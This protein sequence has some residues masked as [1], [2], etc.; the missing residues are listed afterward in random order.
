MGLAG[1]RRSASSC[2]GHP[3]QPSPEYQLVEN[4]AENTAGLL[5]LLTATP[6]QLGKESH[7]AR[8]R[9]LDPDRFSDLNRFLLEEQGYQQLAEQA[10]A[11]LEDPDRIPELDDLLDQHG[12]GRVLFRNTRHV[13]KGFPEREVHPV[14]LTADGDG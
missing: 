7:F 6:E 11:L 1:G 10:Q 3:K 8:L 14:A 4:L 2:C 5:L 12:T 9:L 13:V